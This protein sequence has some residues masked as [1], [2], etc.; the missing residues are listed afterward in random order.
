MIV[1]DA[2]VIMDEGGWVRKVTHMVDASDPCFGDER[3]LEEKVSGLALREVAMIDG[4]FTVI[5]MMWGEWLIG[6]AQ[7]V[8]GRNKGRFRCR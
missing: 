7:S 8:H 1:Y 5:W 4:E 3:L 2:K 6:C